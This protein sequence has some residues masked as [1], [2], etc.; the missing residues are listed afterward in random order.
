LG[1]GYVNYAPDG[2]VMVFV[3]KGGRSRPASNPPTDA[4]KVALFRG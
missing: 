4:E 2:R 1:P 3:V